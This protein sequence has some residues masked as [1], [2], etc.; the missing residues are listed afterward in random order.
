MNLIES[1]EQHIIE[2][3]RNES[4]SMSKNKPIE[5][6]MELESKGRIENENESLFKVW[7]EN[8]I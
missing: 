3:N 1:H 8:S 7:K 4:N 5:Q 2:L 6:I